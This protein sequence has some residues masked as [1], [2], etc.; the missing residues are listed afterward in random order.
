MNFL[1][2]RG[3]GNVIK[4]DPINKSDPFNS[5][6]KSNFLLTIQLSIKFTH[7]AI[8][9]TIPTIQSNF[10][11]TLMYSKTFEISSLEFSL[12]I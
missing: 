4:N 3:K 2:I 5:L 8:S 7:P 11:Y 9:P 6:C 12:L 1:T 10:V